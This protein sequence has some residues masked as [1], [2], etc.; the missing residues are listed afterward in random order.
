MFKETMVVTITKNLL[1]LK[2]DQGFPKCSVRNPKA[3]QEKLRGSANEEYKPDGSD[4]ARGALFHN[5]NANVQRSVF[6]AYRATSI[7]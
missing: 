3:P 4:P 5:G 6:S 1:N 2:L 7:Q